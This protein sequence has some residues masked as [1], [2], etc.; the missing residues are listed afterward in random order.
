MTKRALFLDIIRIFACLC[1]VVIHFNAAVS[2]YG[3]YG[4]F[5][6]PNSLTP[7]LY[8]DAYLGDIG[9]SLFFMVSGASLMISNENTPLGVF[10]R[11]RFFNIYP[12][13]WIAFSVAFLCSFLIFKGCTLS[14]LYLL[15]FSVLGLDGYFSVLGLIDGS[16]YQVGEWFLGCI[17]LLYLVWPLLRE[18]LKRAP[19]ITWALSLAISLYFSRKNGIWFFVRF[20][21][22]LF[23]MSIVKYQWNRHPRFLLLVIAACA[24]VSYLL[25]RKGIAGIF[26]WTVSLCALLF[27]ILMIISQR[28]KNEKFHAWAAKIS[29]L[30]YPVFLVHHWIISKLVLKFD[31]S[32]FQYKHTFILFVV[33]LCVTLASA[34]VLKRAGDQFSKILKRCLSSMNG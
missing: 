26:V 4:A 17:I 12:T 2:G 8:F 27:V 1:I 34:A 32:G 21:E 20:P 25:F 6:Y 33:Y 7:N 24:S 28:I 10:Y 23:G 18:G 16:F 11:K 14:R 31:L 15:I 5:Y 19:Y 22:L 30:T 3:T 29:G 9:V 13:F